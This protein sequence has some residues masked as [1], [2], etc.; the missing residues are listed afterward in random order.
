[1]IDVYDAK[2]HF[3]NEKTKILQEIFLTREHGLI[4]LRPLLVV[5]VNFLQSAKDGTTAA[6]NL[7]IAR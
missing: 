6:W 4:H 5:V 2:A 1:M 3:C 7:D